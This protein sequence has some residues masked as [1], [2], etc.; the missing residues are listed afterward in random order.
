MVFKPRVKTGLQLLVE[1]GFQR[2]A[3]KRI[4]VVT[5]HTSVTADF[6]HVVDLLYKRFGLDVK[7]IFSPEHGFR[8][9]VADG[10]SVKN[11]VDVKTGI[12]IYSLYGPRLEP[13]RKVLEKLDLIIYDI[14]DVGV[15]FYTYISTLFHVLKS[16]GKVGVRVLV[17]D[18]P[19]PVTGVH[20]EGPMLE[21]SFR[22]FVGIWTV[23][24]RYGLTAGELANLFNEEAELRACVE[25]LKM[26]G[27]RRGMWFDETGL[28]WVPPSPNMPSLSTATV[29]PGTCLLEGTNVSEGRGT[30]KPFE[31]VGAPWVDEYRVI[32]ELESLP[33][34]GFRLRP[35]AFTPRFGK[36]EGELCHGFQIY[37][38]DRDEFK[39]VKFGMAVIWVI[40]RLFAESFRFTKSGGR[41][42]FDLLAGSDKPRRLIMENRGF[43]E[44]AK[45]CED[46]SSFEK[47]RRKYFLY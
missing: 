37:V 13:P 47:L 18:R 3:G 20:V 4:G 36:Y 40:R 26:N 34:R 12:P 21:P 30:A 2:V 27:W 39:P 6:R 45:L 16:A 29:Y 19:N 42:Y 5:N 7:A 11:S 35:S 9:S 43:E 1:E 10:A 14:Q 23:P 15:R 28:P 24:V 25:V 46:I 33:L 32:E 8:G 31:V 17:L 38:T 44:L 22:S 41:Y